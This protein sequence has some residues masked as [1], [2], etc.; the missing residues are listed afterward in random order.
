MA[1]H[2]Q[3]GQKAPAFT[4]VDQDG[5]KV[6]LNELKGSKLVLYFY[7]EDDTPTCTIQACNLRDN[8]SLLK[9]NGFTVIGVSPD[10]EEKHQQFR[11]KYDLPFTLLAD[12][13]HK[14]I[15]K[16]GVWGEKNLYGRKYMGIHR[17]TFV[18]DEN[19]VIQKIFL[20]PKNKAHAE[21]IVKG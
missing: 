19:G 18:I 14:I 6:S 2:L 4:G 17:T 15:E 3:V 13:E 7:P 10:A 5:K 11:K 9:K 1:T 8:Y 20:R 12:P 21:E 16:Y